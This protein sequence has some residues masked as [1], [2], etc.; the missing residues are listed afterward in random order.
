MDKI[1]NRQMRDYVKA[2]MPF[3]NSTGSVQARITPIRDHEIY[4]VYSYGDHY[5]MFIHEHGVWYENTDHYS[6][7][8]SRHNS[9]CHPHV[10]TMP[11]GTERMKAIA[12]YGIAGVAVGYG[13][14]QEGARLADLLTDDNPYIYKQGDDVVFVTPRSTTTY[15]QENNDD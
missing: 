2:L 5:P 6:R 14:E 4:V 13:R 12:R 9:Q 1:A 11:M 7:T 15:K 10:D 8:T 3:N